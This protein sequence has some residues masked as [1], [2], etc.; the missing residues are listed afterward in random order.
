MIK[1]FLF[2]LILVSGIV[3]SEEYFRDLKYFEYPYTDPPISISERNYIIK[4]KNE[5][6]LVFYFRLK[7]LYNGITHSYNKDEI[8][9]YMTLE[10]LE[11]YYSKLNLIMDSSCMVN[12]LSQIIMTIMWN[13]I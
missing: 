8:L 12:G 9:K 6:K 3:Y 11:N 13:C 5:N 7:G 10:N 4:H 2:I 1:K